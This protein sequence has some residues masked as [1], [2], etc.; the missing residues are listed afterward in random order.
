[1]Y[2]RDAQQLDKR[3]GT[4][5]FPNEEIYDVRDV[6][7]FFD[8]AEPRRIQI[9]LNVIAVSGRSIDIVRVLER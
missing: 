2:L 4:S 1:L 6:Q 9:S 8:V 3:A 7:V 5:Y